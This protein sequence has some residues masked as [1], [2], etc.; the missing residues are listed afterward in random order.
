MDLSFGGPGRRGSGFGWVL[1]VL[2]AVG[3]ENC[4]RS[5]AEPEPRSAGLCNIMR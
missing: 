2:P 1:S 5:R 4:T 3:E